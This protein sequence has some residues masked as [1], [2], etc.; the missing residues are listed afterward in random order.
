MFS[1]LIR[2]NVGKIPF[3]SENDIT[4]LY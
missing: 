1:I 4:N 2:V 3:G